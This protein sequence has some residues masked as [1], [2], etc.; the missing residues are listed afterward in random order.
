MNLS[1]ALGDLN[2]STLTHVGARIE[3][4]AYTAKAMVTVLY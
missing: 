1:A 3:A 4:L 2:A